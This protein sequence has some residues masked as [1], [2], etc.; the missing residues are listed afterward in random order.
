MSQSVTAS[1]GA[2]LEL[3]NLEQTFVYSGSFLETITVTLNGIDYVQTFANN[4]T[5]ITSISQWEA[6]S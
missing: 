4:G 3:D 1:N 2:R 5:N 6:Q